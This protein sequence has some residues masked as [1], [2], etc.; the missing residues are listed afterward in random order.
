MAKQEAKPKTLFFF[1]KKK[2][3]THTHTHTKATHKEHQGQDT[4][5]QNG[6]T[7]R[8]RQGETKEANTKRQNEGKHAHNMKQGSGKQHATQRT[9]GNHHMQQTKANTEETKVAYQM[10]N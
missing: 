1:K 2:K 10:Q 4:A 5:E 7:T 9:R 6:Y 8:Y 3:H